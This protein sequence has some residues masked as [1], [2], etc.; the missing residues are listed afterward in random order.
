M[1]SGSAMAAG[2]APSRRRR[3]GISI[4]LRLRVRGMAP[5]ATIRSG[6]V[7]RRVLLPKLAAQSVRQ[8]VVQHCPG[9]EGDE[10]RHEE[11]AVWQVEVDDQG[12]ENGGVVLDDAVD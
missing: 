12:T 10:H 8:L 11:A 5:T 6:H 7:P 3:T 1:A 2:S 9:G 4:F